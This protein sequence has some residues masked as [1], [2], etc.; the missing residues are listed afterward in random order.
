[1]SENFASRT[2]LI[3]SETA[4]SMRKRRS[5]NGGCQAVAV[6]KIWRKK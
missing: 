2:F 6:Q 3:I 4:I 5:L 1:M